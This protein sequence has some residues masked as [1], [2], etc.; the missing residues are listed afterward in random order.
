[1]ETLYCTRECKQGTEVQV[2]IQLPIKSSIDVVT[3]LDAIVKLIPQYGEPG[4]APGEYA[5]A[6]KLA[7]LGA[8]L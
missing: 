5:F 8:V 1:M 4:E 6:I 7:R 2:E 3:K